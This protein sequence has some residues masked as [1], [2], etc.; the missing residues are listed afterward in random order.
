MT[1]YVFIDT[2]TGYIMGEISDVAN[3]AEAARSL[4]LL[5]DPSHAGVDYWESSKGDRMAVYHVYTLASS[6]AIDDG[7]DADAISMIEDQGQYVATVSRTR[8]ICGEYDV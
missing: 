5:I 1:R 8:S 6:E 7:R 2:H 4:D 3:P